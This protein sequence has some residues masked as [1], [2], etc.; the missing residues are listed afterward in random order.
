MLYWHR[1]KFAGSTEL[2]LG[3]TF[4]RFLSP[5]EHPVPVPGDT[6]AE[7]W[8]NKKSRCGGGHGHCDLPP[9]CRARPSPQRSFSITGNTWPP[10]LPIMLT[11]PSRAPHLCWGYCTN[12][13]PSQGLCFCRTSNSP[14]VVAGS[15]EHIPETQSLACSPS[16]P[17]PRS[18]GRGTA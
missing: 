5:C 17:S 3:L 6:F 14:D 1:L 8:G 10:F 4:R 9:S 11:L 16:L 18:V 13:F 2:T 15:T 7:V 12:F